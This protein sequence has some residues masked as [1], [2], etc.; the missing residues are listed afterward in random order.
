LT[1]ILINTRVHARLCVLG[2]CCMSDVVSYWP[3]TTEVQVWSQTNWCGI[4]DVRGTDL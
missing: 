4:C 3:L 1:E 2:L